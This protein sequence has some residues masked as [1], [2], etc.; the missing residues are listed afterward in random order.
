MTD[1]DPIASYQP[2]PADVP[3]TP[4]QPPPAAPALPPPGPAGP[5]FGGPA[6]GGPAGFEPAPTVP[7]VATPTARPGGSR[8]KWLVALV[9][10]V[11]VAGTAAGA[12]LLLTGSETTSAVAAWA[13][14]DAV[15]YSEL[16]LDLSGSQGSELPRFMS[17]FP[18]FADQAAF[19]TKL[20]ELAD[21]LV[22]GATN[23]KHSYLTEIQPW[24]DGQVALVQGP[25][26]AGV[27]LGS[28]SFNP[29]GL[30]LVRVKDAAAA[31]A[32][33][34]SILTETG[35]T[36]ATD[37]TYK[38]T[39]I[40]VISL[41]GTGSGSLGSATLAYGM[42][43]GLLIAGD[44]ASVQDS[45]DT[46]GTSGLAAA[47]QFKTAVSTLP[48]DRLALVYTDAT[49]SLSSVTDALGSLDSDGTLTA[50]WNAYRGLTPAW[51]AISVRA[52][53]GGL[54]VD[55]VAP[56]IAAFGAPANAASDL[57]AVAPADTLLLATGRDLGAR[58]AVIHQ[59]LADQPKLSDALGQVD[60]ALSVLGGFDAVTGWMGETG[61]AITRHGDAVNGGLLIAPTDPAA[62]NR[63]LTTIRGLATLGAGGQLQFKEEPYDGTTI[64]SLDLTSLAGLA[65]GGMLPVSGVP[66]DLSLAWAATDRVVVLGVGTDFVKDVLDAGAGHSLADQARFSSGLDRVGRSSSG[67]TWVDIDGL[68]QL[69]ES[70]IPA[71]ERSTYDTNVKPYLEPLDTLVGASV[72]GTDVDRS[73]IVL[74]VKP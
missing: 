49:A 7:V 46:G 43:G 52:A 54:V 9:V 5:A 60:Q 29:R 42:V 30:I 39:P 23:D 20:G 73:T 68:R 19:G 71:N 17:A 59:A 61:V 51:T 10:T 38:G 65:G 45:I 55:T 62:G 27:G 56:H 16:R 69:V 18:G 72:A 31:K 47:S 33:V 53:D 48:G 57:A 1:Q 74:T 12:T 13:P 22:K 21:E 8:I 2:P 15:S 66:S 32:W 11:L 40:R 67:V 58:L 34:E 35:S 41:T 63:L 4:P 36:T 3:S 6:F 50:V 37:D 25:S 26:P 24:F 64:V 28:S 14:S 44:L 70:M